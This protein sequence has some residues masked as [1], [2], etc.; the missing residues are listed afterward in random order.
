[1]LDF[2]QKRKVRSVLY[3]P[4]TITAL[5]VVVLFFLHSTWVVYGKK[6]DSEKLMNVSLE[7]VAALET[8]DKE[9][10]IKIERLGTDAGLEEEIRSKFSVVKEKEYM[11][12]V[13]D[14]ENGNTLSTTT[15]VSWW[16][17]FL[18]FFYK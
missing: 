17:K 18:H 15:L 1:M 11:V 16:Q 6:R 13:V 2:A 9:L 14:R 10:E 3:H 12:V 4:Y 8:R 5:F 7:H